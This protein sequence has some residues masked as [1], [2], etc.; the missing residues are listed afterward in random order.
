M[1]SNN[2]HLGGHNHL[3]LRYP[4]ATSTS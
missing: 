4:S 3:G 2:F 1:N